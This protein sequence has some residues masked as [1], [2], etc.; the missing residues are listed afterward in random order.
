MLV[1]G[2]ETSEPVLPMLHHPQSHE[3]IEVTNQAN[4]DLTNNTTSSYPTLQEIREVMTLER[5]PLSYY[6]TSGLDGVSDIFIH[7]DAEDHIWVFYV[8]EDIGD[9]DEAAT[10]LNCTMEWNDGYACKSGGTDCKRVEGPNSCTYE[11]CVVV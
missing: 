10:Q 11:K 1:F 6:E 2:C 7:Q 9:A 8:F 5:A 4:V 3:Q